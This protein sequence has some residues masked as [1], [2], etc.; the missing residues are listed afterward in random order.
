MEEELDDNVS[1][2]PSNADT[3]YLLNETRYM[4]FPSRKEGFGVVL[5]EAQAMGVLCFASDSVP[6]ET[7]AGGVNFLSLELG[8]ETWAKTILQDYNNNDL[9]F[10]MCD[11]SRFN[12]TS[13][14]ETFNLLYSGEDVGDIFEK[15]N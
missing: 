8:P 5:I 13:T 6:V 11:C 3:P 1:F 14:A 15:Y 4:L 9:D 7:N 10:C 12:S 2:Y